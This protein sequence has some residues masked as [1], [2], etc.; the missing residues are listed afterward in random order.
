MRA[1]A[2][3]DEPLMLYGL[4]KAIRASGDID[5]L[6]AF[7]SCEEALRYTREQKPDVAFLDIRM[8]GMGGM[9]LA[10]KI[11][12]NCPECKIIFC[13]GYD[14]YAVEAFRIH[15][16]GYLMKPISAGDVQREL[17]HILGA[18]HSVLK[19]QCFGNF[20]ARDKK[21]A[22]LHFR[23]SKTLELLAYLVDRR[24]AGVTG[25]EI[26]ANLWGENEN[27]QRCH[28]YLRQLFLDLRNT[29]EAAGADSVL[30]QQGYRYRICPEKLECDYYAYLESGTP[31]F[32]G[33]YMTQYS[34]A[35]ET[36]A[37]L[38]AKVN[39]DKE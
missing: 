35:E 22:T 20:D 14:D 12:E 21:G 30:E 27:P 32:G 23:R 19:V 25:R 31:V 26:A 29:L 7:G 2:V 8:R 28:N 38:T 15:A 3:D 4:S 9:A 1:I 17:D 24:G 6:E 11:V 18:R 37:W 39:N 13:T 34:W 5:S 33:E 16:S 10:E 36:C